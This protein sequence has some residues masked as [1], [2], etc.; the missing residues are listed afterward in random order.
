[1]RYLIKIIIS[2]FVALLFV[3][4][5]FIKAQ[6][7][8]EFTR[9]TVEDGLAH[10]TVRCVMQDS[11]GLLWIATE[12]GINVYDGYTFKVFRHSPSDST[13]LINNRIWYI[14]E[15][16]EQTIW[17]VSFDGGLNQFDR[18]TQTFRRYTHN[19]NDSSSLISNLIYT[20]EATSDGVLWLGTN[21]G[22]E[23]AV[24]SYNEKGEKRIDRF[25]HFKPKKGKPKRIGTNMVAA[26][27][28]TKK[29]ILWIGTLRDGLIR[30]NPV[31]NTSKQYKKDKKNP[32]SLNS[33]FVWTIDSDKSGNLWIGTR[34][35]ISVFNPMTEKFINYEHNDTLANSPISNTIFSIAVDNKGSVWSGTNLGLDYIPAVSTPA[36]NSAGSL[37]FHHLTYQSD[38]INSISHNKILSIYEDRAGVMWV[39]TLSGLN[40]FDP[41]K[42]KFKPYRLKLDINNPDKNK[43]LAICLDSYGDLW[44]GSG[45]VGLF[46]V[47]N[48]SVNCKQQIDSSMII[49][50]TA[51]KKDSTALNNN[52]VNTIYEDS[53]KRLWIGT[54]SGLL[55][56]D[57][58]KQ[59]FQRYELPFYRNSKPNK[60]HSI[61]KI[62]ETRDGKLWIIHRSGAG[63][64]DPAK[65]VFNVIDTILTEEAVSPN[66][67]D[68]YE[69]KSGRIWIGKTGSGAICYN[70]KND[71]VRIYSY[72]FDDIHSISNNAITSITEDINGNLWF[73][74]HVG[75]N[76]FRP[77]TDDF[78]RYTTLDGLPNDAI[79][80]V[81]ADDN[82][83]IWIS[84]NKGLS[85]YF[86]KEDI[87]KNYE[88]RD[89]LQNNEFKNGSYYMS[90]DG[91]MF[92]G[93]I[94]GFN[95]F[96]PDSIKDNTY[97]PPVVI[98]DFQVFNKSVT[99]RPEDE[100]AILKKSISE[101]DIIELSYKDYVFSFEFASLHFSLPGRNEYKYKL[102]NF[103]KDW[104]Y[105]GNRNF[106]TFS[107]IP[108]G[109]YYFKVK[110]SNSDGIWNENPTVVKIVITP[111]FWKT[112]WFRILSGL[113]IFSAAFGWYRSRIIRIKRQNEKL[114][115]QVK[116]RTFEVVQQKEEIEAQRD[117]IENQA[118]ALRKEKEYTLGSIRYAKTIQAA[119]L[120]RY[121]NISKVFDI[122]ILYRPKDI[123]SGDFYWYAEVE[124]ENQDK[125]YRFIAA[126]DCTGHGVPGAFMSMI[127]S[128]LLNKIV[129]EKHITNPS[130][131]L[132]QL[133]LEVSKALKQRQT[134]NND[135]MDISLCRCEELTDNETEVI[136]SGA[137]QA[138]YYCTCDNKEIIRIKG[139][140]KSIGGRNSISYV[141]YTNNKIVLQKGDIMYLASDGYIDQNAPD[142]KRFG[143]A[144]FMKLLEECAE[145]DIE[146]QKALLGETI[147][148][149]QQDEPQRDDITVLGVRL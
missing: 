143:I 61:N 47:K 71:S 38:D 30:F 100:D 129:K 75:L 99:P 90:D 134:E 52:T 50:Y 104:N 69:D 126:V 125:L 77:E 19:E 5:P 121:E 32:N 14:K 80:G 35:G 112:W 87:F 94:D 57:H 29:G 78:Q 51:D 39:G 4:R 83:N 85:K 12:D 91:I 149:Y 54:F 103:D 115:R 63:W 119:I 8:I 140:R 64:I 109:T 41:F 3:N 118:K 92:F 48:W 117:E 34:S 27:H 148:N 18:K 43:I 25:V 42:K 28:A 62:I 123:V 22:L 10:N 65:G 98:T 68:M 141:E 131:I 124:K 133:N 70:P 111:P 23:K 1:M 88:I 86:V 132:A 138:L 107:N 7:D 53:Q 6:T 21:K 24:F 116:E 36:Y 49:H 106:A 93:G 96:H 59:A 33:N 147:E 145:Y 46:R 142:R 26:L 127:G 9:I 40:K 122:F 16:I 20:I 105:I 67:T 55:R 113:I 130:E 79:N 108:H 60:V 114:E 137:K 56:F 37:Q 11:K 76:R 146:K 136:F 13:S 58:K 89:G 73:G 17:V 120:P 2:V 135:G 101:T 144:A 66:M 44:L 128:Q 74:T 102:E 45:G 31:M 72:N 97:L 81:L 139:D 110:G 82:G 84:T 15:D 95:A